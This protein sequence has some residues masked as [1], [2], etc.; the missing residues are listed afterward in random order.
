M[1][2]QDDINDKMRAILVDWIMDVC[3]KYNFWKETYFKTIVLIDYYLSINKI[4][5]S[6]LQL[7]GVGSLFIISKYE[8]I[9]PPSLS[10]F[11]LLS[12]KAFTK[13]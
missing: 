2:L 3:V 1:S 9:Y 4:K 8:E 13:L 6:I 12:D 10:K 7:V 5:K 11:Y